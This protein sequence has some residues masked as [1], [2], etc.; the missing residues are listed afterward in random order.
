M[1]VTSIILNYAPYGTEF[2][3]NGLGLAL[4]L[5]KKGEEVRVFLLGDGVLCA[6][7]NQITPDG[8]YN[9]LRMLNTL[10]RRSRSVYF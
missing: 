1:I 4:A 2:A 7:D 5:V 3:Y 6:V 9:I 8:Y 10:T